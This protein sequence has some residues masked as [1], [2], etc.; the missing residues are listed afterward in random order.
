VA[1]P[2]DSTHLVGDD[3]FAAQPGNSHPQ[4]LNRNFTTAGLAFS[5][6][7]KRACDRAGDGTLHSRTTKNTS[8]EVQSSLEG[9]PI[10]Q[11]RYPLSF[12]PFRK[13]RPDATNTLA[14]EFKIE[15]LTEQASKFEQALSDKVEQLA[16]L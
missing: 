15:Q 5:P 9:V 13:K 3:A 12:S 4:P 2:L 1:H 10:V 7:R 11:S 16:Q 8:G 6:L 14:L